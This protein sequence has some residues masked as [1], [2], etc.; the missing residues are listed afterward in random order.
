MRWRGGGISLA[1][2]R[3]FIQ[4]LQSLTGDAPSL[5]MEL[6]PKEFQ[7]FHLAMLN[8][9]KPCLFSVPQVVF[10]FHLFRRKNFTFFFFFY[11]NS[12]LQGL[13]P[14]SFRNPYDIP[15]SHLLDQLSR[16]RRN[17]LNTSVCNLRGQDSGRLHSHT[18]DQ[19]CLLKS[20]KS[21]AH[22]LNSQQGHS[23]TLLSHIKQNC[24]HMHK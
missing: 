20:R 8:K 2:R 16:M 17:L 7:G 23:L 5:P 10:F 22:N 11:F 4:Q 6:N 24:Q 1:Q 18:V 12:D 3:D 19:T 9:V 13:K 21:C 14:Q 15:R